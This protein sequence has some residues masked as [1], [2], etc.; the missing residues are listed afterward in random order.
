MSQNSLMTEI[1]KTVRRQ[2]SGLGD[3]QPFKSFEPLVIVLFV[4]LFTR[5]SRHSRSTSYY[6]P[7][8]NNDLE[9]EE[10]LPMTAV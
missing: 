9:H 4:P 1:R 7:V 6:T 10:L 8:L 3:R 2:F 5:S